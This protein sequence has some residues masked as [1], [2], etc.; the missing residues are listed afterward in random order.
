M[1]PLLPAAIIALA[2]TAFFLTR[3]KAGALTPEREM[4]FNK[5]VNTEKDPQRLRALAAQF[6]SDGLNV[7]AEFLEK[8]AKL[9]ELPD[10]VKAARKAAFK[11][12]MGSTNKE[13]ILKLADAY[14][15]EAATGAAE[16]L[17]K[18]VKGLQ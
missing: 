18:Y 14:E 11:Q 15:R 1:I 10:S 12:A 7:Q 5:A 6:R 2:G 17:R 3:K 13:A 16:A 9:R 4:L 8:R